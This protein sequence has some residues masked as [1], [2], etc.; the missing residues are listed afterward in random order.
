[1]AIKNGAIGVFEKPFDPKDLVD[2]LNNY[3]QGN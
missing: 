1:M 2:L 3:N